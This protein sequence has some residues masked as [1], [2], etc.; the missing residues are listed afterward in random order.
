MWG[1][2]Y[3]H[4]HL[5]G[6]SDLPVTTCKS[7]RASTDSVFHLCTLLSLVMQLYL[8][9]GHLVTSNEGRMCPWMVYYIQ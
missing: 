5:N 9:L 2:C 3:M 8:T 6:A 4:N 1:L 7:P